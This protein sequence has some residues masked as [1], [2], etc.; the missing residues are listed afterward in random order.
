[1]QYPSPI[2]LRALLLSALFVLAGCSTVGEPI[3][4]VAGEI[5]AT[6]SGVRRVTEVGDTISVVFPYRTDWNHETRIR[7]DGFATFTL[8][9]EVKVVKLSIKELNEK[10]QKVYREERQSDE[11]E[12]VAVDDLQG[13][14]GVRVP[15]AVLAPL[16]AGVGLAAVP[17][18]KTGIDA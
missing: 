18:T 3:R 7:D 5:N 8:V 17:V 11:V 10:L 12:L 13:I 9:G 1:M 4:D 2:C 16:T 15:D 14:L 6:L